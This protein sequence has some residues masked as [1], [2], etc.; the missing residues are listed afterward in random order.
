MLLA[1]AVCA[2]GVPDH[3]RHVSASAA[4]P[5]EDPR[6]RTHQASESSGIRRSR[7]SFRAWAS[8]PAAATKPRPTTVCA[9]AHRSVAQHPG[10]VLPFFLNRIC[11]GWRPLLQA[12]LV[13]PFGYLI[14]VCNAWWQLSC[15]S[16][17]GDWLP[18]WIL[19]FVD[20]LCM[21]WI[22]A[23]SR[24]DDVTQKDGERSWI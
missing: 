11:S 10:Y 8:R 7:A 21:F 24:D 5:G 1:A 18:S 16:V 4:I 20:A 23:Q 12:F 17:Q 19:G 15:V 13:F 6:R 2:I 9:A 14:F 3:Q 22:E